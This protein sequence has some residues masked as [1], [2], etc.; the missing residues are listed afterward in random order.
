M[1]KQLECKKCEHMF[2]D[3]IHMSKRNNI[4]QIIT[5]PSCGYR[6]VLKQ[7]EMCACGHTIEKSTQ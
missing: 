6:W 1:I 2:A 7:G 3:K 4:K 5:C